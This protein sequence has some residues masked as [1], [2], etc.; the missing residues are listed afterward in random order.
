MLEP[1]HA[2]QG[3]DDKPLSLEF[4]EITDPEVGLLPL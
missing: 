1:L 2:N 3:D 4:G